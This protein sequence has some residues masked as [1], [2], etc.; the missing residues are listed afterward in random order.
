MDQ[1]FLK[2]RKFYDYERFNIDYITDPIMFI[3]AEQPATAASSNQ[4]VISTP[5]T[6]RKGA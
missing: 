3:Y 2:R 4:V 1:A 5:G 6:R